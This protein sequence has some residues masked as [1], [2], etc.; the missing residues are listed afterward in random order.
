MKSVTFRLVLAVTASLL[1]GAASPGA[2]AAKERHQRFETIGRAFKGV[3]DQLKR[4]PL[5]QAALRNTT[6]VLAA[7]AARTKTWF[8]DGSGPQH[9]VKTEALAAAWTNRAELERQAERFAAAS[10]GLAAA[11]ETGDLP[12]IQAAVRTTGAT[13]KSCHDQFREEH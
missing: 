4:R 3:Q 9:G 7:L 12:A 5:N 13:C 1:I 11:A 6:A 10:R 2:T 8:P